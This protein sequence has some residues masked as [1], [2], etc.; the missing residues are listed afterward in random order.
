MN[1]LAN[2][3]SGQPGQPHRE[4][5][6]AQLRIQRI[7]DLLA[8]ALELPN[9]LQANLRACSSDLLLLAQRFR[10]AM[11]VAF[12]EGSDPLVT[13]ERLRP[14][15]D[16]YLRIT[17]QIDRLTQLE[18]LFLSPPTDPREGNGSP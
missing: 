6:L 4:T 13:L 9:A 17:R 18:R 10:Q 12:G 7:Q 2:L 15:I 16:A 14:A 5:E 3:P 8:E 11:N 1:D